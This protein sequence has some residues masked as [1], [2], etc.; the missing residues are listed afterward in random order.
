M[1]TAMAAFSPLAISN[2]YFVTAWRF[3]PDDDRRPVAVQVWCQLQWHLTVLS[4]QL[5]WLVFAAATSAALEA[6]CLT[7]SASTH[8]LSRFCS[9]RYSSTMAGKGW[10]AVR[11]LRVFS[12][13][14]ACLLA[15][16]L[17]AGSGNFSLVYSTSASCCGE[18]RFSSCPAKRA[19]A[20][21]HSAIRTRAELSW[22]CSRWGSNS[23]PVLCIR[24]SIAATCISTLRAARGTRSFSL[25]CSTQKRPIAR[26]R[27][28]LSCWSGSLGSLP[29]APASAPHPTDSSVTRCL[30]T[31]SVRQ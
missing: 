14:G 28:T 15:V 7:Q 21:S 6:A 29:A 4:W 19:A 18:D 31:S 25:S 27:S 10:C 12:S 30:R 16:V 3:G 13:V 9:C 20:R 5:A 26:L 17:S 8:L 11:A 22:R 2:V 24:A 1:F 23:T